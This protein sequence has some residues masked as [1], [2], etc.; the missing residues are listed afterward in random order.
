MITSCRHWTR[1]RNT[2]ENVTRTPE[3]TKRFE[4][5]VQRSFVGTPLL[6]KRT[7][8]EGRRRYS[9]RNEVQLTLHE[10]SKKSEKAEAAVPHK[11]SFVRVLGELLRGARLALFLKCMRKRVCINGM[12]VSEVTV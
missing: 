1:E 10:V 5:G 12:G 8:A 6:R 11:R 7:C 3:E 9:P 2:A 4:G